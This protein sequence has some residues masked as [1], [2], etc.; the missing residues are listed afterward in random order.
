MILEVQVVIDN[1]DKIVLHDEDHKIPRGEMSY[2]LQRL[3]MRDGYVI[4]ERL[5]MNHGMYGDCSSGTMVLIMYT[6]YVLGV[7]LSPGLAMRLT[8]LLTC[9]TGH[10]IN[11]YGL[12][13][14]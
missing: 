9:C 13:S 6:E 10:G 4:L 11:G 8:S 12:P 2:E 1:S 7:S 5:Y 14:C 3:L